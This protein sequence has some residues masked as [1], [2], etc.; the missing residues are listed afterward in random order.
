MSR[1]TL[2]LILAI[3]LGVAGILLS[4]PR[5]SKVVQR[6]V[7]V[8]AEDID[9]Y[10]VIDEGM[11]E[12]RTLLATQAADAYTTTE[13]PLMTTRPIR[14]G[15]AIQ[16]T[17]ALP[18]DTFRP[19]FPLE[20]ISFPAT[21]D[22]MVSGQVVPGHKINIYGYRPEQG[23]LPGELILVAPKV[24]VV[25]VRTSQGEESKAASARTGGSEGSLTGLGVTQ[26]PAS[27]VTVATDR[28][29]V[30]GIIE[31]LG[32]NGL[33]AWVT[34]APE[35]VPPPPAPTL[36]VEAPPVGVGKYTAQWGASP[37]ATNYV[38]EEAGNSVFTPTITVYSGPAT[39]LTLT[40]RKAGDYWYRV[41]ATNVVGESPWSN[42]ISVKVEVPQA[43]ELA[44]ISGNYTLKW[45]APKGATGYIVQEA[46]TSGFEVATEVYSGTAT[47]MSVSGREFGTY[48]YRVK[49][50]SEVGDSA[51]SNTEST[52]VPTPVPPTPTPTPTPV[53]ITPKPLTP[54]PAPPICLEISKLSDGPRLDLPQTGMQNWYILVKVVD[55]QGNTQ[56][57]KDHG[58][59]IEYCD[60][61]GKAVY[62]EGETWRV[63]DKRDPAKAGFVEFPLAKGD[64]KVT[65]S[66]I[67]K[68]PLCYPGQPPIEV[69]L[70][71]QNPIWAVI[72]QEKWR[73]AW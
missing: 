9:T 18:L 56:T 55:A 70:N 25:D 22:K 65:I 71:T 39:S 61:C 12:H 27:I 73:F 7:I 54:T 3:V 51:W 14:R 23:E 15:E 34:L 4:L 67:S 52:N 6:E 50:T 48:Y 20:V 44:R 11:V 41:K 24:W 60:P 33:Q 49:A 10:T 32:Q 13:T 66:I 69:K 17:N 8:A 35:E 16:R 59:Q 40:G 42:T 28:Q 53:V 72:L 30:M 5:S 38:L 58:I 37:R 2:L 64:Y 31:A 57:L 63:K 26:A 43:P 21:V 62:K 1:R 29:V 45:S 36:R 68:I 19:G 47:T 46:A